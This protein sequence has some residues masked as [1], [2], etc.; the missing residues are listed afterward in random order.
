[1]NA[2]LR[3]ELEPFFDESLQIL[4]SGRV[5]IRVENEFLGAILAWERA[6][7][8]PIAKWFSP[9]LDPPR[10][11]Q[12]TTEELHEVLW[13]IIQKLAS[14]RIYLDF[15]DHLS[16]AQLYRLLVR[17]IL[18]SHEKMVD[19]STNCI[20]F[21]CAESDADADTWLRYYASEEERQ[22]WMEETGEPLPP[23]EESPYPRKLPHGTR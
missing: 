5:P 9:T 22:G 19:L 18:P 8:L 20:Y 11:D 21:N 4:D 15:T 14:R 12:L 16:D 13:D 6:P 3:D 23:I 1:M 10:A 17:D 2:K 7:V